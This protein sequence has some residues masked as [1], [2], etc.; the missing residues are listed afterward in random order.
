MRKVM[1]N[2]FSASVCSHARKKEECWSPQE[3]KTLQRSS[4]TYIA[5]MWTLMW[6]AWWHVQLNMLWLQSLTLREYAWHPK[7]LFA[8]WEHLKFWCIWEGL[9]ILFLT[10]AFRILSMN[11]NTSNSEAAWKDVDHKDQILNP[12][13][14]PGV[15]WFQWCGKT[16]KT[17][18]WQTFFAL[19]TCWTTAPSDCRASWASTIELKDILSFK[20][21]D[22][23]WDTVSCLHC[24]LVSSYVRLLSVRSMS[25]ALSFLEKASWG[26]HMDI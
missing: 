1:G 14:N 15:C 13:P 19:W 17:K 4:C 3:K 7:T 2:Q 24:S 9:D 22:H 21:C 23:F 16:N 18:E 10:H 11:F 5:L 6:T 12:P 25:S 20:L 8:F 26:W